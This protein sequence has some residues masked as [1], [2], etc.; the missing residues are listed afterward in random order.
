M[1][2]R[3]QKKAWS[4]RPASSDA[5]SLAK[6]LNIS[7]ILAQLLI[8]RQ[9]STETA[10]RAFL[11]PKLT[12]LINPEAMAGVTAAAQR[13]R[14]AVQNNE[15]IAVYGDYDVDGITGVAI[16]WH[17]LKMLNAQ[18]TYYIPHRIEE[19][20][21]LNS[22]AITQLAE[23][24]VQLLITV[25]CGITATEQVDYATSLGMDVIITDHHQIDRL[26]KAYAIVHPTLDASYGNPNAC[27]AMAAFKLAW[28]IANAIHNN[29]P[30]SQQL[31]D[32][33]VSATTLAGIGTIA[34]VV[35]LRG[36]NR[37]IAAFGL[38]SLTE[39]KLYGIKA[40][41]E[42]AQ[43]QTAG[44]NSYDV[45]FK[46]APTLNAAGRMGHA[47]LAVELLTTDNEMRAYQIA[48][49]LKDQNRQRQKCQREIFGQAKQHILQN[50]LHHPDRKTIVLSNSEWHSGVIGIVASRIIDEF[51]R[52]TVMINI[53]NGVGHGSG[54]SIEGFNLY[55]GLVACS[56]HLIS[57]GGHEMAAGLRIETANI[58][59]FVEAFE[60]YARNTMPTG[61][62]ES[63]LDIEAQV[64]IRDFNDSLMRQL[65]LMEPFGQGNFRPIFATR[66]VRR[67]GPPRRVGAKNEHLQVAI[68]DGTASVRCIGFNMGQLEKKIIESDSFDVAYEPQINTFNGTS[69]LQFVLS[70]IRFE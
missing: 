13:I 34:D 35:D 48:Q 19:G 43:L 55:Q 31:R 26:P 70:D 51:N 28:A 8:N 9:I 10:A 25:D 23:V 49:Y 11:S 60:E 59:A 52:P 62:T 3:M 20:Y 5:P 50:N 42:S 36:E 32:Y 17:L 22:D 7:P 39:S 53:S 30:I 56:E 21:G 63:I 45:A 67:I 15:K 46:L 40:L 65:Q 6:L 4:V 27:G 38:R 37:V 64:S 47:R 18:V 66:G 29:G 44:A 33:L 58:P 57:F 14:A 12:D 69:S 1:A 68:S 61:L 54:R 16:L 2:A 41:V 24:G